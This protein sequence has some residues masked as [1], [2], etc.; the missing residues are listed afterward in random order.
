MLAMKR[1]QWQSSVFFFVGN[2]F[3]L[4]PDGRKENLFNP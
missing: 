1:S 3:F 2:I 4:L